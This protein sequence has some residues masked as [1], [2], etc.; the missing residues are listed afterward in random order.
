MI[1]E[2]PRQFQEV[3]A[4]IAKSDEEKRDIMRNYK[5]KTK[6]CIDY[7]DADFNE[8]ANIAIQTKQRSLAVTATVQLTDEKTVDDEI[9]NSELSNQISKQHVQTSSPHVQTTSRT[10]VQ[11]HHQLA[12]L[13][14]LRL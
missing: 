3:M 14:E 7:Y 13:N 1:A 12:T 6:I 5:K 9:D 11:K 8:F 2:K 10:Y 4:P